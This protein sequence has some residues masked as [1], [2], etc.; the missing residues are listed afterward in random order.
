MIVTSTI[1]ETANYLEKKYKADIDF[2]RINVD[3]FSCYNIMVNNDTVDIVGLK[4][5]R[6]RLDE[7]NSI[8]YRKPIMPDISEFDAVYSLMIQKDII[9]LIDG[10]V[11][12]FDRRVLTKPYILRN[13]EN[14]IFQC[15]YA[16]KNNIKMPNSF[17]GN[18]T[19]GLKN[20]ECYQSI[21]KPLTTGKVY[22]SDYCELYQTSPFHTFDEDISLTPVYIQSFVEKK[23]EVRLTVVNGEFFGVKIVAGDK[24]DWRKSYHSN[25]YE[26]IDVPIEIQN[27]VKKM[28]KDFNIHFGAFD[29][30]ITSKD[31]W[32]FL[33]V[34]PNGQWLWL[35]QSLNLQISDAIINYLCG[36]NIHENDI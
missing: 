25:M 10:M 3:K 14:K 16:S 24:I 27:Q 18:S 6:V 33:E 34:N 20:M 26:C 7:I 19:Q 8:L 4:E 12:S 22:Y 30:I 32:I 2:I 23:Y 21:I 29:Y 11:N 36:G 9:A 31:E 28:M 13:V 35:E 15:V 17:I 1:D 5:N